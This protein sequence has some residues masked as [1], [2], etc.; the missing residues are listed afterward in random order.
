MALS[1][2][3][4]VKGLKPTHLGED[5]SFSD[6]SKW[7]STMLYC[8]NKEPLWQEF[9]KPVK[10]DNKDSSWEKLTSKNPNRGFVDGDTVKKE[11]KAQHLNSMLECV[12][13]FV[14]DFLE[15][16]IVS[17]STSIKSVWK[18]IRQYYNIQQSEAHFLTLSTIRW[19]GKGKERPERLYRR[20]LS[21]LTDNLMKSE[22]GLKHN[23]VIPTENEDISP[24]VE[25][26]AVHRWLELL[27]PRL[28]GLVARLFATD[29]MTY[30]LKDLQPMI[31]N[32]MDSLLDQLNNED[33]HLAA[34]S[35]ISELT[36]DAECSDDEIQA[37]HVTSRSKFFNKAPQRRT[38]NNSKPHSSK[39]R[40][41]CN[42]CLGWGRPSWGHTLA[43]CSYVSDG[44]RRETSR[45]S[46][47]SFQVSTE[48]E[49]T[50]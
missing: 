44:E 32:A 48:E 12:A 6:Y 1:G 5:T 18:T 17:G 16:E 47:K 42:L 23:G 10:E 11:D 45:K 27:D 34:A 9:L 43:T 24:T 36:V 25:R 7:Q 2:S 21:H 50:H 35:R 14:P 39:A 40:Q 3:S 26:L 46:T 38:G 31:A 13:Q 8:L 37:A 19:E 41:Q 4:L 30:S 22:G 33:L 28:P 20:I 15:H 29:L 49:G